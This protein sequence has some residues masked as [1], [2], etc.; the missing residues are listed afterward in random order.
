MQDQVTDNLEDRTKELSTADFIGEPAFCRYREAIEKHRLL[1]Q[2]LEL[3]APNVSP[4]R[5]TQA[6][7]AIATI[8]EGLV[9]TYTF[10]AIQ[11]G[12][13]SYRVDLP[14]FFRNESGVEDP[15]DPA[16]IAEIAVARGQVL[17]GE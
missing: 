4:E 2:A 3:G 13:V 10:E 14:R 6:S 7:I 9:E 12:S 15:I 1:A 8:L 16:D 5:I 17:D 11:R